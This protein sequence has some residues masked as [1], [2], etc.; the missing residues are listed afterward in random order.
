LLLTA[1]AVPA[2]ESA[3]A[4][5]QQLKS[6]ELSGGSAP[7]SNVVLKRD[8]GEMTFSSGTFYF[9]AP[10]GG[11]VRGAVFIGQGTFRAEV[12]PNQFEKEFVQRL[13]KADAVESD[14]RTAVLRFSDDTFDVIGK[15]ATDGA[16]PAEA[17]K[18]AQEFEPRLLKE[19]GANISARLAVSILNAEAPGF[20]L[21]QFDGGRRDRFNYMLDHQG[22]IPTTTFT[23][24]GGEK[25]LIFAYGGVL[26]GN[27]VWMAFYSLQ[28]YE[29]R[30]VNY[31]DSFDLVETTQYAMNVDL[32][33]PGKRMGVRATMELVSQTDGLRAIPFALGEDMPEYDSMRLKKNMRLKSAVTADGKPLDAVQEDWEG[34]LTV[35]LPEARRRGEAFA[36][37][38]EAEGDFLGESG[39]SASFAGGRFVF[40]GGCYYP[41]INGEWYPRHGYLNRSKFDITYQH[42]KRLRVAGNGVRVEEGLLGDDKDTA[43]TRWKMEEPVALVTFA[44]G[45]FERHEETLTARNMKVPVEFHSLSGGEIAIKEDF[46]IAEMMNALNYMS[47]VFGEYPYPRLSGVFHP[48]GFGQG[49]ATLLLIPNTDRASKYTYSFIAHETAHQWWGNIVAWRSYRDQWLSEGFAEYSGVLYTGLRDKSRSAR[50]LV[51][52]MRRSLKDPPVTQTGVGP[53]RLADVGPIIMGL[54][55]N[56]RETRGAYQALIYNKGGLVLRMLHFLFTDPATGNGDAFFAMMTDFVKRHASGWATTEEFIQVANEHFVKTQVAQK[57]GLKDLNWFFRQWV[58]QAHFPS[59]RMEY[60]TEQGPDGSVTVQGVVFQDNAPEDWFMP[61]PLVLEF[62]KNQMATGTVHAYGP[63][64]PFNIKLPMRPKKVELDPNLWVLS[65]KTTT[66]GK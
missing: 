5:Y 38:I 62:D 54:R 35:F 21:A 15:G 66:R 13:L 31:S 9:Q 19:S 61:L 50:D 28:D 52:D 42:K 7:A 14:F 2:Q 17:Q 8:R 37:I 32:R 30:R 36:I 58:Y 11:K 12:P 56:T 23:I 45:P 44:L 40:V 6:F 26:G 27:D 63:K 51:N 57:Y 22:R 34:G 48:Y 49:F 43:I 24:N 33:D 53:G 16:A 10:V 64:T 18:L 1:S 3:S 25:G 65:E 55:L 47:A 4:I 59:Y 46:I 60:Q 39:D 29:R 20:F 41:W